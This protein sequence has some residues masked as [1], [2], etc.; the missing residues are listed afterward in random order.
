ML[1]YFAPARFD[2]IRY[3]FKNIVIFD[4]ASVIDNI[5]RSQAAVHKIIHKADQPFVR[6]I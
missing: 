5:D 1:Q 4:A 6:L 2:Y 3:A